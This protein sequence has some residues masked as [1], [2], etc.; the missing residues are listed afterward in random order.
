MS[1]SEYITITIKNESG[2]EIRQTTKEMSSADGHGVSTPST[3]TVAIVSEVATLL[4][5]DPDALDPLA[6]SVD[7]DALNRLIETWIDRGD[8]TA[9]VSFE[10]CGCSITAYGSGEFVIEKRPRETVD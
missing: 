3:P 6:N 8:D 5:A 10:Y 7:P 4:K 2:E 1:E 9:S